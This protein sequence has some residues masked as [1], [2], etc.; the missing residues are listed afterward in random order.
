MPCMINVPSTCEPTREL[1]TY[2]D[3]RYRQES[4]EASLAGEFRPTDCPNSPSPVYS[5]RTHTSPPQIGLMAL[6]NPDE[7]SDSGWSESNSESTLTTLSTLSTGTFLS[8]DSSTFYTLPSLLSPTISTITTEEPQSERYFS[9]SVSG[10]Y[11]AKYSPP[12]NRNKDRGGRSHVPGN[13]RDVQYS[14]P[15]PTIGYDFSRKPTPTRSNSGASGSN[16]SQR[17]GHKQTSETSWNYGP[18][19][20]YFQGRTFPVSPKPISPH[21]LFGVRQ[22]QNALMTP[23]SL[24]YHRKTASPRRLKPYEY[25]D[26]NEGYDDWETG[27]DWSTEETLSDASYWSDDYRSDRDYS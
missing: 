9:G 2:H 3:C 19:T 22:S 17:L 8:F 21:G 6:N 13:Y 4:A 5:Q 25:R 12:S 10:Y 20:S 18:G 26:Y 24:N 11:P 27:S 16:Q 7:V 23:E 1:A 15:W 14:E